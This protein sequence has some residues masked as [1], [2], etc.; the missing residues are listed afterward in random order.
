MVAIKQDSFV[1]DCLIL[2]CKDKIPF[3]VEAWSWKKICEELDIF[4]ISYIKHGFI[5]TLTSFEG[6]LKYI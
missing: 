5:G 1:W 6:L 2:F 3:E 4:S